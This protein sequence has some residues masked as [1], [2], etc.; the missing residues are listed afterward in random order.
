MSWVL[1][2]IKRTKEK[3]IILLNMRTIYPLLSVFI[4]IILTFKLL[5]SKYIKERENFIIVQLKL[6]FNLNKEEIN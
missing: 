2:C 3:R 6:K 1:P 5:L 4:F